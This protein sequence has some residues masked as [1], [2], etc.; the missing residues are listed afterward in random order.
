MQNEISLINM[1]DIVMKPI[2]WLWENRI[3]CGKLTVVAGN[4][5]LGKSQITAY[6]AATVSNGI[7]WIDGT[8]APQGNVIFLSAEDCPAD[9][10]KPR[11]I[12]ANAK[13]ENCF[14]LEAV[15]SKSTSGKES[16]RGFD[17]SQDIER[18]S[19]LIK[20]ISDVRLIIIDPIS[21]YLGKTDSHNNSD[22]RAV[23]TP[24]AEMAAKHDIAVVVL[25]HLNKS[26]Q[27]DAIAR[28]IGSV[29]LIAAARAG[30]MVTKDA[31]NPE[32]RYFIP[33]K[34]NIG[35]DRTGFAYS[36]EGMELEASIKTSK[37]VWGEQVEA[38]KILYPEHKEKTST[39]GAK[40]FLEELLVGNPKPAKEVLEE[41]E[42]AGY[43]KQSIQRAAQKLGIKRKKVGMKNGWLWSLP[44]D[45]E[46][47][48]DVTQNMLIPSASSTS[49]EY[50][51]EELFL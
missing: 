30:F 5:G 38:Q 33:I 3:A 32:K 14:V 26:N 35:N 29:G 7:C 4:P 46:G 8:N 34:N 12:A 43:S 44:E 20:A 50:S 16:L 15:K 48:E 51:E 1:Q 45:Y 41:A 11:L 2:S 6:L 18:L 25:T 31:E 9:T 39:N 28:V 13:I 10:I 19:E 40:S 21:S 27:Q 24:L 36:I 47:I 49:S 22:I 17:I 23:L 37:I 42:G